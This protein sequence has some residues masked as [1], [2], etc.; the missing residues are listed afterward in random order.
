MDDAI[1]AAQ[2]MDIPGL[3]GQFPVMLRRLLRPKTVTSAQV[4]TRSA[5]RPTVF[6]SPSSEPP[7]PADVKKV[8]PASPAS[9]SR[10]ARTYTATRRQK[11][12]QR[13]RAGH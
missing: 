7:K 13:R 12:R 8:L 3:R 1:K 4:S 2:Y 11:L 5:P 6:P 9:P 10:S